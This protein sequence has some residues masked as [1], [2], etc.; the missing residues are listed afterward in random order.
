MASKTFYQV[1][2][3]SD[4]YV[5]IEFE[6]IPIQ[7]IFTDNSYLQMK[8]LQKIELVDMF[9]RNSRRLAYSRMLSEPIRQM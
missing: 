5:T 8:N 9:T 4:A 3:L 2:D 6:G 7:N 1:Y